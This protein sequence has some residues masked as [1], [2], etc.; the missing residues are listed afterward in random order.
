ME[1]TKRKSKTKKQQQQQQ[2]KS[3]KINVLEKSC[4]CGSVPD[5]RGVSG[6]EPERAFFAGDPTNWMWYTLQIWREPELLTSQIL[7]WHWQPDFEC[8]LEHSTGT[9]WYFFLLLL[10]SFFF[11][12]GLQDYSA[13]ISFLLYSFYSRKMESASEIQSV[14]FTP[15]KAEQILG[16]VFTKTIP[17]G[18][19]RQA[20]LRSFSLKKKLT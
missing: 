14:N 5:N 6:Q 16:F 19:L 4:R 1:F 15:T 8:Y 18:I 9:V 13:F 11:P 2:Q 20:K 3:F 10:L 17:E 7:Q 12:E